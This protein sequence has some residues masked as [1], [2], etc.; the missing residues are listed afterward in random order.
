M[1]AFAMVDEYHGERQHKSESLMTRALVLHWYVSPNLQLCCEAAG[2]GSELLRTRSR[3]T[4]VVRHVL[5]LRAISRI[6]GL[7]WASG[8]K[9]SS[10]NIQIHRC[11]YNYFSVIMICDVQFNLSALAHPAHQTPTSSVVQGVHWFIL[12]PVRYL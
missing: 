5:G 12:P 1:L 4:S 6:I 2:M 11:K 7:L 3:L 9:M 10:L 8:R